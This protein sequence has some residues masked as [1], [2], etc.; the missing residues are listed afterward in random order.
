MLCHKSR[1]LLRNVFI[2]YIRFAY[3]NTKKLHFSR[4]PMNNENGSFHLAAHSLHTKV[5]PHSKRA[6][7]NNY[8]EVKVNTAKKK[9]FPLFHS[10][11]VPCPDN[12]NY[13]SLQSFNYLNHNLQ[14]WQCVGVLMSRLSGTVF[15]RWKCLLKIKIVSRI[16]ENF[17]NESQRNLNATGSVKRD[18]FSFMISWS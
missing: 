9:L 4:C 17:A 5:A 6:K 12:H 13:I 1:Q 10:S 15:L 16:L 8:E 7:I 18:R 3:Y 11:C 14:R 2:E